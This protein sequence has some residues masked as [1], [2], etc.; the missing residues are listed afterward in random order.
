MGVLEDWFAS[1]VWNG[2]HNPLRVDWRDDQ[3]API[4]ERLRSKMPDAPKRKGLFAAAAV[5]RS[6]VREAKLTGRPLRYA[7]AKEHYRVPPRYRSGGPHYSYRLVTQSVDALAR[8][9]LVIS[10]TG[11]HGRQSVAWATDELMDL[12]ADLIDIEERPGL[13]LRAETIVLRDARKNDIEYDDTPK[14]LLMRAQV[15]DLNRHLRDLEVHLG[16][17]RLDPPLMRRI[18]NMFWDRGGRLYAR[19][20]S[21]QNLPPERRAE[22]K[23]RADGVMRPVVELDFATMHITIA[24]T[25]AEAPMPPGDQYAIS[26]FDR[27]LVK[28]AVNIM[29]NSANHAAAVQAI[30]GELGRDEQLLLGSGLSSA[31][32]SE[33]LKFARGLVRA[34]KDKHSRIRGHFHSDCGSGFQRRDSDIAVEV[35]QRMVRLTGR[36][37]LPVHD[38]FIVADIDRG[39]LD[40]VMASVADKHRMPLRVKG[41]AG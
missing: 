41:P 17:E 34:I 27:D 24:Y 37:P 32:Q 4:A 10:E 29:F 16:D 28:V 22:L 30:A 39:A 12:V 3:L 5:T 6:L 35:M 15:E 25:E 26:D 2:R 11:E 18:F 1:Q 8:V 38:S 36:C 19:G 7:R 13:A 21:Y 20:A 33:R 14:T 9:G 23:V 31:A 40:N